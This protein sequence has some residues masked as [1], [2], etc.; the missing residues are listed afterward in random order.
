MTFAITDSVLDHLINTM[1]D[2]LIE[3]IYNRSD[4]NEL[5]E[6]QRMPLSLKNYFADCF[7]QAFN[8]A[9]ESVFSD[10]TYEIMTRLIES[11]DT[12]IHVF[13]RTNRERNVTK[14]ELYDAFV[15]ALYDLTD[16]RESGAALFKC[17]L[18]L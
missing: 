13:F 18:T 3:C 8:E 7:S 2:V 14:D 12:A 5:F 6:L 15:C 17:Y 9:T 16:I 4:L 1:L 10:E 11:M